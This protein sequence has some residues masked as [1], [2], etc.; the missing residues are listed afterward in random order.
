VACACIL[1]GCGPQPISTT[2]TIHFETSTGEEMAQ[3]AN[4][5]RARF[6]TLMPS[7]SSSFTTI[8]RDQD[9]VLEFRGEAPPDQTIRDYAS[10]GVLRIYA[11]E[12][13]L[14]W[15][16]T[17]RDIES[18]HARQGDDG[19]VLD[20]AVN[21][22]AGERLHNYTSRSVGRLLVTSWNG[23]EQSRARVG[24]VFSRRFQTT[25]KDRDTA[26]RMKAMLESG[27]LPVASREIEIAHPSS[28]PG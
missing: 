26:L 5:L 2:A 11:A 25:V 4:I 20:L 10:Q 14:N 9:I 3:A 23:K 1:A 12:S 22:R 18:V 15:L 17:D 7:H 24:G 28:A 19:P 21:E 16:V 6:D 8:V 13:P 27:R